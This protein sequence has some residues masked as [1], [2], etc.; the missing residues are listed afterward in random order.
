M[1]ALLT[2]VLPALLPAIIDLVKSAFSRV[3][4]IP[5]GQPQNFN[6]RLEDKKLDIE[7]LKALAELDRPQGNVSKWVSD[8]RASFRYIAVGLIIVAAIIYN[9]LPELRQNAVSLNYL[10]ELAASATFFIIGDRVY[11][12]L[13]QLK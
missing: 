4:G 1:T 13:K 8:F 12:G 2:L 5:T 11:L 9:F 10:N 3:L 6:E 7:K